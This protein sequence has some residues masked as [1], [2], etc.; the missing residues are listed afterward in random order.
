VLLC[1]RGMFFALRVIAPPVMTGAGI[2][3]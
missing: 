2:T 1:G 3:A